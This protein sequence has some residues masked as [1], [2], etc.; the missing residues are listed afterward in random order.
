MRKSPASPSVKS[1]I[2][3]R[4]KVPLRRKRIAQA[5]EDIR[6]GLKDTDRRG[7]PNDVP[8]K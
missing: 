4:H 5:G 8:K 3:A 2:A 7:V 1:S 6:R